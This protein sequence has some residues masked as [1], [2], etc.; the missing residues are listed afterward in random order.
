MNNFLR[1][2]SCHQALGY[3]VPQLPNEVL[4]SCESGIEVLKQ[5][6]SVHEYAEVEAKLAAKDET[7]SDK[8]K[9]YLQRKF[10]KF[11]EDHDEHLDLADL[12]RIVL[13][14]GISVWCCVR[15]CTVIEQNPTASFE[16]LRQ[17]TG[18]PL[19]QPEVESSGA[20]DGGGGGGSSVD[21]ER[22]QMLLEIEELK[23]ALAEFVG[24]SEQ[25]VNNAL[26]CPTWRS[27]AHP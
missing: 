24:R 14:E 5:T 23:A 19:V 16:Q 3:P 21:E 25:L 2:F 26:R 9:G 18:C 27:E 20:A 12:S 10:K 6:S 7:P 13:S 8:A 1:L 11:V 15:C 22:E 17:K 4:R